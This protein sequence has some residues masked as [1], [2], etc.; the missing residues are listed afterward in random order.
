MYPDVTLAIRPLSAAPELR[1]LTNRFSTTCP[2]LRIKDDPSIVP[3]FSGGGDQ[4]KD[5][6]A[7]PLVPAPAQQHSNL[8]NGISMAKQAT[9]KLKWKFLGW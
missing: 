6:P 9:E 3:A 7:P 5:M 4:T 8:K 1:P 2:D